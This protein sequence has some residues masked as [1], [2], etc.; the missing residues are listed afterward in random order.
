[1]VD[2]D[3]T[4]DE[5]ESTGAGE[6]ESA[7]IRGETFGDPPVIT[8]SELSACWL[9][10]V[11][12]G[13]VAGGIKIAENGEAV[14]SGRLVTEGK[15][16]ELISV[17]I[18]E[19]VVAVGISGTIVTDGISV[20]MVTDG[21]SPVTGATEGISVVTRVT[22]G[23]SVVTGVTGKSS[24]VVVT[25]GCVTAESE[26]VT[27]PVTLSSTDS[28]TMVTSVTSSCCETLPSGMS[29]IS[30]SGSSTFVVSGC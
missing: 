9:T 25:I 20:T 14:I 18:W 3:D 28:V 11:T 1:M 2:V 21:I 6:R 16:L 29:A 5:E 22:N 26:T 8:E 10:G 13:L 30:N 4:T 27:S 24:S 12:D 7:E 17:V 19:V 23:V 15:Q